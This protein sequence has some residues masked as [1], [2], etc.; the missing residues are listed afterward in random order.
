MALT[1]VEMQS[2]EPEALATHWGRIIGIPADGAVVKLPN[3]TFRFVKGDSEIMS[4][5][6][7]K[8][9]DKAKVLEAAK[10]RGCAVK[11]DGFL[12]CGVTFKLT[13]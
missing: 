11:G 12:L 13:A 7:F 8:V 4:G 3:S 1:T 10:A 2:P 6:T 9:A 5:L